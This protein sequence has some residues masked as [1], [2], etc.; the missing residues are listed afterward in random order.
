MTYHDKPGDGTFIA[1]LEVVLCTAVHCHPRRPEL[2]SSFL[3]F[4]VGSLYR[5]VKLVS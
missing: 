3:T 4:L 1:Q 5:I 2:K